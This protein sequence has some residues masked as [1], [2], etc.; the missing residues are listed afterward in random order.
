[1]NVLNFDNDNN[2][3]GE[4]PLFLGPPL[5]FSDEINVTYKELDRV[6]KKQ[7]SAF[8]LETEF[9]FE[10]DRLDLAS[11]PDSET[12]VMVLNIL[13]QWAMDAMASRSLI[14]IFGP[15][16]SNTELHNWLLTQSFYES[17]HA[18][19]YSKIVRNCFSDSNAVM[20]RGKRNLEVFN[21]C[22]RIGDEMNKTAK[23]V[24]RYM[25]GEIPNAEFTER[26]MLKQ[27][28][29][30]MCTVFALE[31]ISFMSSFA[32]TFA[33]VETGKYSGIGKAVGAILAD[34]QYHSEGDEIVTKIM[35][36]HF[37]EIHE[38]TKIEVQEIVDQITLQ[39]MRWGTYCFSEGRS[40]LGLNTEL[41]HQYS[42]WCAQPVYESLG[43][44]WD[45]R[46]FLEMPKKNPLPYMDIHSNRDIIQTANQ[47]VENNNYRV[48][49][50]D[51]D[52]DSLDF[53][54]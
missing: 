18:A 19:T 35:R 32:T 24:G 54:F 30:A 23:M 48:G 50:I 38:E 13:S 8:W 20:E 17:I 40:I 22:R 3:T 21:R 27:I 36:R 43:L 46:R 53:E 4:Y 5:G 42:A 2:I 15:V 41:L 14:E 34:E 29:K 26:D 39:E 11:A 37:P 7:R 52:M 45:S 9:S 12:D 51:D 44:T 10:Q 31:Q 16:S 6:F 1:M 33:L 28:Y 47:E 25:A 49:Q